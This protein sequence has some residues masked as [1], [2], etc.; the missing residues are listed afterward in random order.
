MLCEQGQ[1]AP[2]GPVKT[3]MI[4]AKTGQRAVGNRPCQPPVA[5]DQHEIHHPP[6]QPPG[7]A[8]GAARTPGDLAAAFGI[9]RNAQK[10]RAARDDLVQ[11]LLGIE[12]QP[13]RDAEAV[14][15]RGGQ[16]AQPRRGP[17][18]R[19]RLQVDPHRARRRAFSDHQIQCEILHGRIQH[20]FHNRRQAVNLVDEQHV[21]RFKIGQDR[22]QIARLGQYRPRRHPK[23]DAKLA[24]HDLRQRGLAQAGRAVKQGV[25]HRLAPHP[26][27]VDE[28][29]QVR[30]R[31]GLADEVFQHLR[32]QGAV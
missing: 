11:L 2:V 15:Q 19:E 18:Q 12:L 9:G 24:R 1:I 26:G 10:A 14:A 20:F 4:D 23:P 5:L 30:P 32:A 31:L 13:G 3:Q 28:D 16:Q 8:R 25:I 17:D 6:Q 27:A 22:R 7:N 29:A 21:A